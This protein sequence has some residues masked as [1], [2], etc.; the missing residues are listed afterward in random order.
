MLDFIRGTYYAASKELYLNFSLIGTQ[1]NSDTEIKHVEEHLRREQEKIENLIAV[2]MSCLDDV[3][4]TNLKLTASWA[5]SISHLFH[6]QQLE[7]LHKENFDKK[8]ITKIKF[9]Q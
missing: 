9:R 2:S 1:S 3:S 6:D 8:L 4:Y 5:T 7:H